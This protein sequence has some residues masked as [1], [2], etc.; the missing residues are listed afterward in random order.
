MAKLSAKEIV[1][2]LKQYTLLEIN[3]L[4]K[5]IE[6]EFNISANFSVASSA[7]SGEE[8]SEN[9]QFEFNLHLTSPGANK[10]AVIK[11]IREL[12]GLGLMEA[13]KM[14]DE[15]PSLVKEAV[16][17]AEVEDL[18]KKFVGAGATVEFK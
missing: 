1:E 14:V 3:D 8:S 7:S 2:S 6:E 9:A 12:T 4:V 18:K 15:T 13:K 10:I 17:A 5:T 16:P 11:V